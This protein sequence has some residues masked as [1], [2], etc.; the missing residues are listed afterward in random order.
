[1]S[2][3][4]ACF[5]EKRGA[6]SLGSADA[7]GASSTAGAAK[8][9]PP[10]DSFEAV[11]PATR[12]A[13]RQLAVSSDMLQELTAVATL[14]WAHVRDSTFKDIT[15]STLHAREHD[16]AGE[17]RY[18]VSQYGQ[19][20]AAYLVS[21][22]MSV[23]KV[24]DRGCPRPTVLAGVRGHLDRC[25]QAWVESVFGRERAAHG[26]YSAAALKLRL[27]VSTGVVIGDNVEAPEAVIVR[28]LGW[29]KPN[30]MSAEKVA[31]S[32]MQKVK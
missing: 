20:A 30:E 31:A 4:N 11:E 8:E 28:T 29:S 27:S 18:F 15:S 5:R 13:D 16:L 9:R 12:V 22:G 14:R 1:M 25:A 32:L 6:A 2:T 10:V 3:Y 24:G 23:G 26:Q 17:P 7:G 21:N 19:G